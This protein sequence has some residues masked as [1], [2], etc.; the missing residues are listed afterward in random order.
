VTHFKLCQLIDDC[1]K[2]IALA[3][4]RLD[5]ISSEIV[6]SAPSASTNTGSNQLAS[7]TKELVDW[8]RSTGHTNK[9][10]AS[11]VPRKMLEAIEDELANCL[12]A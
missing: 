4:A 6:E 12:R 3:A 11:R 5:N 2:D 8:L 10:R 9:P 7:V 1:K